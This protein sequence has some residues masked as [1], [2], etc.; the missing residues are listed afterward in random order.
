MPNNFCCKQ[1]KIN[2]LQVSFVSLFLVLVA[3]FCLVDVSIVSFWELLPPPSSLPH[4]P[5]AGLFAVLPS[6]VILFD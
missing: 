4:C 3:L 5:I 1:R 2:Y 6:A